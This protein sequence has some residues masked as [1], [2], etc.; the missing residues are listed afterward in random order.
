MKNF[1]WELVAIV[2]TNFEAQHHKLFIR[3][4]ALKALRGCQ[5]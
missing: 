2:H 1:Q 3:A 4:L 5:N